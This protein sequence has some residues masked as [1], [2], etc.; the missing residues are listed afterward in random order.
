VG[1]SS[2]TVLCELQEVT[3][4]KDIRLAIIS[5]G[6]IITELAYILSIT[7]NRERR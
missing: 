4:N 2:L 3:K 7:L 1:L 6:V 5:S